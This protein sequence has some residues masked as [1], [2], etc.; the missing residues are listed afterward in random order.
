MKYSSYIDNITARE[1]GL[2]I[3]L[4]YLFD[5]IYTLPAWADTIT[6]ENGTF[7]FASKTKAVEELPILTDK[8][9]TMYRYY[10]ALS[11]FGLINMIKVGRK[12]YVQ[13]TEKA[14][15]WG[16]SSEYSEKNPSL[17][18]K[19]SELR[20]EKNPTDKNT[21]SDKITIEKSLGASAIK[22]L[23]I[24]EASK[25][26]FDALIPFIEK[27]GKVM[28]REFFD[29]WTERSTDGKDILRFQGE[30]F[31]DLSRRLATW[32]KNDDEKKTK[33]KGPETSPVYVKPKPF[34]E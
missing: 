2:N 18:G 20:S 23:S 27:Y 5:W 25:W 17:V 13:L 8:T 28:L 7:Y 22:K 14:K 4:A 19:K 10:K 12:D 15:I 33:F 34:G 30:K 21:I 29:Y 26:M 32:K 1:W 9:D 16:K 31:F 6:T 3:Q 24:D 11:D